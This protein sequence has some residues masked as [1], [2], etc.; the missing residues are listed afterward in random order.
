[1]RVLQLKCGLGIDG[2]S[3]MMVN[4]ARAVRPYGV[5]FDVLLDDSAAASH[6]TYLK[7][8]ES[9]GG[10]VFSVADAWEASSKRI[11]RK[12]F[13]LLYSLKVMRAGD[14]AAAHLQT[15]TPSRIQMLMV[16]K[17]AGIRKRI[18][19]SHNSSCEAAEGE[20]ARQ[21]KYK[22][23]MSRVATHYIACSDEAA[24][25]LFPEDVVSGKRYTLLKNGIDLDAYRFDRSR[26]E[27]VRQ[28]LG[29]EG[30][31]AIA[32]IGRLV[33]QKNLGFAIE[34]MKR[35]VAREPG[36][37]LFLVGD[38]EKR[39]ELEALA[40]KEGVAGAVEFL[41]PRDDVAELLQAFDVL[42]M[43]SL[44][45]GLPVVLVEAQAAS[46]PCVASD[47]VSRQAD[48]GGRIVFVSLDAPLDTWADAVLEEAALPRADVSSCV[49][50]SGFAVEDSARALAEVY[51]VDARS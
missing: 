51:G 15:D 3:Q 10:R 32:C 23:R 33:A 17:G 40:K 18:V 45:E 48:L 26:R 16:A 13:K 2:A 7:E 43:P 38:G 50:D 41:G 9:L 11:P 8:L 31:V 6:E 19:H 25:W 1:M 42:L 21:A 39:S 5:V 36:A 28:R 24:A 22:E 46:L 35:V 37:K 4:L 14:Y 29:A 12:L 49:R 47:T 44:F 34:V 27:S 20:P 30:H